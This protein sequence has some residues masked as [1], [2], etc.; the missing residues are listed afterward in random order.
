MRIAITGANGH[1]GVRLAQELNS[2]HEVIALVRSSRARDK[3]E[4]KNLGV[5]ITLVDYTDTDSLRGALE[6]VECVVHLVGIIKESSDSTFQDAHESSCSA[7]VEALTADAN[8]GG[9]EQSIQKI[10]YLSIVGSHPNSANACLASKGSGE[11]IL[12]SSSIPSTIMQVPMVLGECDFASY[13]LAKNARSRLAFTFR[14]E[15]LEQ[16]IYA[17][18]VTQAMLKILALKDAPERIDLAGPESVS[19]RNLINRAARILGTSPMLISLPISL[20]M[21]LGFLCEFLP[22]PP[23]TRSM[24]GVLD[25]DD[26]LDVKEACK[27][28]G[29]ELTSLDETLKKVL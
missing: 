9:N 22:R 29:I 17:G 8:A 24:L 1:L 20:G 26:N 11:E 21:C 2:E 3:M 27:Q 4:G 14:C 13:A 5:P 19:R 28:L 7:L 12:R 18:D 10:I 15:S 6:G 23:V 16:P 25:H